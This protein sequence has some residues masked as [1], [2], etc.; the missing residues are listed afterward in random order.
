MWSLSR[1]PS[2]GDSDYESIAVFATNITTKFLQQAQ[3]TGAPAES[4]EQ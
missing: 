1:A 3:R 4:D 2:S